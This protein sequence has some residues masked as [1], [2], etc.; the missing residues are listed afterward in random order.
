MRTIRDLILGIENLANR[1]VQNLREFAIDL[2]ERAEWISA[3]RQGPPWPSV[4]TV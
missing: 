1:L 4:D 3:L 2:I